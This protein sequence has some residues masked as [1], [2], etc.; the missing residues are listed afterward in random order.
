MSNVNP[1]NPPPQGYGTQ[2]LDWIVANILLLKRRL[3][4]IVSGGGGGTGTIGGTISANQVAVGTALD[5]IGGSFDAWVDSANKT[6]LYGDFASA[7]PSLQGN[8]IVVSDV[9]N[10]YAPA[11]GVSVVTGTNY[12]EF[13]LGDLMGTKVYL[14]MFQD[15]TGGTN[16]C[17]IGWLLDTNPIFQVN[18]NNTPRRD[19]QL[20]WFGSNNGT[21]LDVDDITKVIS[22]TNGFALPTMQV[23]DTGGA[24][25]TIDDGVA[26]IYIDPASLV[27]SL[28]IILPATPQEGQIIDIFFGGVITGVTQSVVT[29]LGVLPSGAQVINGA[30][31][32]NA[33]TDTVLSFKYRTSNSTWYR[34]D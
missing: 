13:Q 33:T 9:S 20:G 25:V 15:N 23:D 10:F 29:N 6:Y 2:L 27:A 19:L 31:P 30:T 5:T 12:T 24:T 4:G 11:K 16:A 1:N 17:G 34:K 8:G 26:G 21:Y 22:A 32:K 3:N 18:T 28:D 14:D 7:T